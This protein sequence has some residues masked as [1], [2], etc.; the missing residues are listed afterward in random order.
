MRHIVVANDDHRC[1]AQRNTKALG[2]FVNLSVS[3]SY[4]KGN[5]F[6]NRGL[7]LLSCHVYLVQEKHA[8]RWLGKQAD[9]GGEAPS[10]ER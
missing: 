9:F 7:E 10:A 2:D 3:H 8:R 6:A 4:G 1:L 5:A